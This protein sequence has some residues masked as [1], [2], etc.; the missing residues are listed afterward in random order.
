MERWGQIS[1]RCGTCQHFP[2]NK[3]RCINNSRYEMNRIYANDYGKG[4]CNGYKKFTV[5]KEG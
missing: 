3:K 5:D 4:Y 2:G 1:E